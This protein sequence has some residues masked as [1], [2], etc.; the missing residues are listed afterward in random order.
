MVLPTKIGLW[1]SP[2]SCSSKKIATLLL[3]YTPFCPPSV[4]MSGR[5]RA[6]GRKE[7]NNSGESESQE[8]TSEKGAEIAA[9]CQLNIAK[10]RKRGDTEEEEEEKENKYKP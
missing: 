1:V 7:R 8:G 9:V 5:D 3:V 4:E 6:R 2:N 10:K